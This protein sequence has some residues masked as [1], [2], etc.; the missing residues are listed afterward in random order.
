MRKG[1]TAAD[2]ESIENC[3]IRKNPINVGLLGCFGFILIPLM[4]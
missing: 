3:G 4:G 1:S 2:M